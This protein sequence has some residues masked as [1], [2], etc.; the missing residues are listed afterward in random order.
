LTMSLRLSALAIGLAALAAVLMP[1]PEMR[2]ALAQ[3]NPAAEREDAMET[4]SKQ[5]RPLAGMARGQ[6][7]FDGQAVKAAAE[8]ILAEF[9]RAEKLFPEGSGGGKSRA[10]P[11][12]WE[13]PDAFAARFEEAKAAASAVAK[14]GEANSQDRFQEAFKT[15]GGACAACHKTFRAPEN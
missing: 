14:A 12:I 10:L 1:L 4:I 6:Q 8:K 15:L 2:P 11:A 9:N 7:A 3:A 5:L 13:Q